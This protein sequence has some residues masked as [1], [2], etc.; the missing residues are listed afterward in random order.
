MLVRKSL[1]GRRSRA[2]IDFIR[3]GEIG[4]CFTAHLAETVED[5]KTIREDTPGSI[6][7][8]AIRSSS[9]FF[10]SVRRK[11]RKKRKEQ[12]RR[13]KYKKREEG[14]RGE[15]KK[16]CRSMKSNSVNTIYLHF[17]AKRLH[18]V[19]RI[20]IALILLNGSAKNA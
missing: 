7:K 13:G 1:R 10:V 14:G 20:F 18:P 5:V 6:Q 3:T 19:N 17:H 15:G 9:F 4:G 2:R 12:E 16:R 11:E 8:L